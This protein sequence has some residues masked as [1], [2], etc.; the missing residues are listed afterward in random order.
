MSSPLNQLQQL[1]QTYNLMPT[2][3][4]LKQNNQGVQI[5]IEMDISQFEKKPKG[6][7]VLRQVAWGKNQNEAKT[8]AVKEILK[9]KSIKARSVQQPLFP[10]QKR[11][12]KKQ[13]KNKNGED[14]TW[15]S[16]SC[17]FNHPNVALTL[18][19]KFLSERG[20]LVEYKE[21]GTY[22][23]CKVE[24]IVDGNLTGTGTSKG[25]WTAKKYAI[26]Q[27]YF[28]LKNKDKKTDGKGTAKTDAG[29]EEQKEEALP[30]K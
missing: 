23:E 1:A 5:S 11:K 20:S 28:A 4:T 18:F 2:I 9:H 22:P 6:S 25:K 10:P 8:K 17:F 15:I 16:S 29:E 24:V 14:G 21:S 27:A 3:A 26:K 19:E 30:A 7:V 13:N 12:K